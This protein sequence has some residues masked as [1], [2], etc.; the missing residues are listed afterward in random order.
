MY[1]ADSVKTCDDWYTNGDFCCFGCLLTVFDEWYIVPIV[2][3]SQNSKNER[4]KVKGLR[5]VVK[6]LG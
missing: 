6:G 3:N 2:K 4:V 1:P 5:T